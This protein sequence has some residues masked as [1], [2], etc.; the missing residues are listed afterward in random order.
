MAR[1]E[2]KSE[3]RAAW[4]A[5]ITAATRKTVEAMIETGRLL[6]EAKE[7]LG[8]GE[9]LAMVRADLPFGPRTAQRLMGIARNQRLAN[10]SIRSL[11]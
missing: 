2:K 3:A 10:A 6:L 9:F 8:H 7:S 1:L 11:L 5:R 4:A